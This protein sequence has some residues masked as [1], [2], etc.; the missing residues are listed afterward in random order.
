MVM[1][2]GDGISTLGKRILAGTKA[3]LTF[4]AQQDFSAPNQ[5]SI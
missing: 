1:K 2:N 3:T 5:S 4:S